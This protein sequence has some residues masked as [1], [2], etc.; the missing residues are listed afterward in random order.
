M[1]TTMTAPVLTLETQASQPIQASAPARLISL[2][3][4]APEELRLLTERWRQLAR[5]LE[6]QVATA[7]SRCS[8][9]PLEKSATCGT[10][11]DV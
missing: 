11:L 8:P 2:S 7:I 3:L 9:T 10:T 5:R 4:S 6:S 1:S